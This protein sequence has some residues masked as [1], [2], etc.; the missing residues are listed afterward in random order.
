MKRNYVGI[1]ISKRT[2]DCALFRE[3]KEEVFYFRVE[4][5]KEGFKSICQQLRAHKVSMK[6]VWFCM[7]HTGEFGIEPALFFEKK[8]LTYSMVP[9]M[10]IKET[11][12]T[13][14]GKSDK[15][16]AYRIAW[17]AYK[18]ASELQPTKLAGSILMK[19]RHLKT[20][21]KEY[22]TT[23]ATYK[24]IDHQT[25]RKG[26]SATDKR[27]GDIMAYME[28]MIKKVDEE[29]MNTLKSDP[30]VYNSFFLLKSIAGVGNVIALDTIIY[31]DN[32]T[33]ITDA[34]KY[35]CHCCVAPFPNS[36][37]TVNKGTHVNRMGHREVKANLSMGVKSAITFSPTFGAY[38]ER[39]KKEGKAYGVII[40][41]LCFKLIAYMFA[42]IRR[43][44]MFV[45][46]D[47]Y[48][49]KKKIS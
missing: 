21:R 28:K 5:D 42:V 22:V 9:A 8:G 10:K 23:L 40:N 38:Y 46:T 34:R 31:T 12:R 2:L 36:S 35:A 24:S 19:L 20:E 44:S 18:N 30:D 45:S 17:F 29:I 11:M 43:Q 7:E 26:M 6:S 48:V 32:F 3:K 14:R 16:D 13:Q 33:S 25:D 49:T 4:N 15:I 27:R 47:K 1:D 41:N 39:K 37:G